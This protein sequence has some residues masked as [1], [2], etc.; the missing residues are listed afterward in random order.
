LAVKVGVPL[1]VGLSTHDESQL[2]RAL[3]E[4]VDY[5]AVGPVF[6]TV[7]KENPDPVLGLD[8]AVALAKHARSVRPALPLVAIGGIGPEAAARLA[9]AFDAVAVISALL[10]ERSDFGEVE[11]RAKAMVQAFEEASRTAQTSRP[12]REPS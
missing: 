6:G 11:S 1:V 5:L 12:P 9:H 2:D 10:P 8:R 3:T 7:S 4:P